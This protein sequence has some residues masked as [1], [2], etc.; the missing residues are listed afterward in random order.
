MMVMVLEMMVINED[1]G[2]GG[3]GDD[4]DDGDGDPH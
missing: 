1:D 3:Y 4:G 2:D